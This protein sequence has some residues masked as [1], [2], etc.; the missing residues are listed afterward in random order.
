LI[1]RDEKMKKLFLIVI[2]GMF[3]SGCATFK[4]TEFWEHKSAFSLSGYLNPTDETRKKSQ[5]E[6]WWGIPIE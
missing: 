3:L 1:R 2:I 6:G 5:E 4:D